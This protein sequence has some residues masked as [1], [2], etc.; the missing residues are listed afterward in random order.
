MYICIWSNPPPTSGQLRQLTPASVRRESKLGESGR[1]MLLSASGAVTCVAPLA[2]EL[3]AA[4]RYGHLRAS[5]VQGTERVV[6]IDNRTDR[7]VN[8]MFTTD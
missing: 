2:A 1:E 5:S 3:N 6:H 7:V 4:S 8:S